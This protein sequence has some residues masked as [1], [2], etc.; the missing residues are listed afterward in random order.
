MLQRRRRLHPAGD[1]LPHPLDL[2]KCRVALVEMEHRGLDPE[3]R[4]RSHA[5]DAKQELLTDPV[6][7]VAAVER[8]RQPLDLEQKERD[9]TD[10]LAPDGRLDRGAAHVDLDRDWLA[11]ESGGFR[12]DGLVVLGLATRCVDAL[13]EV[14]AAVEEPDADER[15]AQLGGRLQV[16]SGEHAEPAGVDRQPLV[17]P[18]LHAE[19]RD[20]ERLVSATGVLPPA[21][22]V[23]GRVRHKRGRY[24]VARYRDRGSSCST[25]SPASPCLRTIQC[26]PC[27]ATRSSISGV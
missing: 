10:V 5:A 11:D 20:A 12:I 3:R 1:E 23:C 7:A 8:V 16:V 15:H 2:E 26:V 24:R 14:A 22:G 9:R 19:V 17:E 21:H 6:L 18:E 27:W 4:E 25:Y 13:A